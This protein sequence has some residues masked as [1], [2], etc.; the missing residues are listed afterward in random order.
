MENKK[1]SIDKNLKNIQL[2]KCAKKIGWIGLH[3][4]CES[5]NFHK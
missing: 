2:E 5:Y 1:D 3:Y 4:A